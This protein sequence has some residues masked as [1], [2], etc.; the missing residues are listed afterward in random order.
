[1]LCGYADG[2]ANLLHLPLVAP[3]IHP[4]ANGYRLANMFP[5]LPDKRPLHELIM[6]H[7]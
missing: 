5:Q 4:A 7:Q 2:T 1:M 3:H 6:T